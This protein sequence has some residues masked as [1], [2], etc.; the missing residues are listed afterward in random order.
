MSSEI[1]T[2]LKYSRERDCRVCRVC[3]LERPLAAEKCPLC[4]ADISESITLCA[5]TDGGAAED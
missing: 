1:K 2:I 3:G 4:S 5:E